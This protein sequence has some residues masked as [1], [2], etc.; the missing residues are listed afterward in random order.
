MTVYRETRHGCTG[1]RYHFIDGERV[2]NHDFSKAWLA[3]LDRGEVTQ[4]PTRTEGQGRVLIWESATYQIAPRY[5]LAQ[6]KADDPES[7]WELR[8][9]GAR[10]GQGEL[11]GVVAELESK[12]FAVIALALPAIELGRIVTA[13]NSGGAWSAKAEK[14]LGN[15]A[16]H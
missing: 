15:V 6:R 4:A 7:K 12:G 11:A 16:N 1:A 10:Y 5:Q 2:S 9:H 8:A 3:A 13:R 14:G